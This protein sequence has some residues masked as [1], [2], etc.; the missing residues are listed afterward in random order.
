VVAVEAAMA[1]RSMIPIRVIMPLIRVMD[2][3][4]EEETVVTAETV[5]TAEATAAKFLFSV[6]I[7]LAPLSAPA[8]EQNSQAQI[9]MKTCQNCHDPSGKRSL[10]SL[11]PD[12]FMKLMLQFRSGEVSA[13][14]MNR[15]VKNFSDEEI[16]ALAL[17]LKTTPEKK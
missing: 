13:T 8:Q 4:T 9:L 10:A 15:I 12:Q 16:K 11:T 2:M 5:A 14:I 6:L 7:L 1:V 17:Y 3:E